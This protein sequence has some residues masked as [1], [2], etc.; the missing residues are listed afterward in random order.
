MIQRNRL[1][2]PP[3]KPPSEYE[4]ASLRQNLDLRDAK[5]ARD[6]RSR[7]GG[8]LHSLPYCGKNSRGPPP[9]DS[10]RSDIPLLLSFPLATPLPA[11]RGIKIGHRAGGSIPLPFLG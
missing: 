1:F 7:T 11:F 9:M 8:H 6:S 5:T 2:L 3:K 4:E 10:S